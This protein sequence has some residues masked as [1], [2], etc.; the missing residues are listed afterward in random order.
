MGTVLTFSG[1]IGSR[2]SDL[3]ERVA[4]EL[5]WPRVKFSDYIADAIRAD[6]E[7]PVSRARLQS[8]GQ[9]LVQHSL[10]EFVQGTLDRADG[11]RASSNIVVDGLRHTE[12]LLQ[13]R[14]ETLPPN[15]LA[16]VHVTVDPNRRE[17]GA[18][19]RGIGED[20][21]YRYDRNLTELQLPEILPAYA[22]LR[23]DGGLGLSINVRK[24]VDWVRQLGGTAPA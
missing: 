19:E 16:Y 17:E 12:V 23:L 5:G 7:E 4:A 20:M 22:D 3:S 9:E 18:R 24:V 8:Y 21:L 11:W 14:R 15:R 6:G 10:E 1:A 2:R 13:L